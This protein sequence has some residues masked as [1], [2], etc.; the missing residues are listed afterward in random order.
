ME[1]K[2]GRTERATPKKRRKER[3]EGKLCM[4]QEINS[5]L[6]LL[7]GVIAL[8]WSVPAMFRRLNGFF[9]ELTRFERIGDWTARSASEAYSQGALF[10]WS[11]LAPL[12]LIVMGAAVVASMAQTKPYFSMK[13]LKWKWS[14]LNPVKG[15]T[16]LFS[17]ESLVKLGITL[18]KMTVLS[19]VVYLF[20]RREIPVISSLNQFTLS[21]SIRWMFLLVF[22]IA[23][24]VACLH[25]IIALLDWSHKKYQYEKGMMMT[26]DEVKDERKQEETSPAVKRAQMRKMR[27]LSLSRIIAAVPKA[28]VI[29][30]NPTHVAVALQYDPKTMTAPKV[31]AK[32]LNFLAQRIKAIAAEHNVPIVERPEVARALY[33]HVD[34]GR[35]IPAK[36]YEAVAA[37]LAFLHKIGKGI[38]V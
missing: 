38:A 31:T 3:E 6:I 25:G 13:A 7:L 12:L 37:V 9:A 36:F 19:T 14:S 22:K 15:V 29:V 32:G 23:I 34:V 10:V 27:E 21:D 8:R 33:K 24:L 11:L 16:K 1:G 35:E 26:K 17:T 30:T 28:S 18:L 5:M 4:S 2:D 20:V